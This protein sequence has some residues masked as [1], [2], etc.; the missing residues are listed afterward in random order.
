[1]SEK[2]SKE[3]NK[4]AD[5]AW[6]AYRRTGEFVSNKAMTAW[7]DTWDIDREQ[8]E[9]SLL[10][11]LEKGDSREMT[12]EFFERLRERARQAIGKR[13]DDRNRSNK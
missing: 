4:E 8:L 6:T 13:N 12:P 10:E 7:L 1:M 9:L 5:A 3:R 2:E 11:A